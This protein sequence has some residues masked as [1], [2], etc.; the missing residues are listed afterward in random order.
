M[1]KPLSTDELFGQVPTVTCKRFGP[2]A[3]KFIE[4]YTEKLLDLAERKQEYDALLTVMDDESID[5]SNRNWIWLRRAKSFERA[6]DRIIMFVAVHNFKCQHGKMPTLEDILGNDDE[7]DDLYNHQD[8]CRSEGPDFPPWPLTFRRHVMKLIM[9]YF[10]NLYEKACIEHGRS[11]SG[12][13]SG[14]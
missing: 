5:A 10:A 8:A 7:Y 13:Y 14:V 1:S 2:A 9:E 12:A 6:M 3:N 4:T 11:R